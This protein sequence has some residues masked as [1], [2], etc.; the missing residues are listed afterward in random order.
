MA[1]KTK[2]SRNASLL[3]SRRRK[4]LIFSQLQRHEPTW[5]LLELLSS[6]V[7]PLLSNISFSVPYLTVKRSLKMYFSPFLITLGYIKPCIK[8]SL[9]VLVHR[10]V[11]GLPQIS[12]IVVRALDCQKTIIKPPK[13]SKRFLKHFF[14]VLNCHSS[15]CWFFF[16]FFLVFR[17]FQV[18]FQSVISAT[19]CNAAFFTDSPECRATEPWVFSPHRSWSV[20]WWCHGLQRQTQNFVAFVGMKHSELIRR[21]WHKYT[22]VQGAVQGGGFAPIALPT[23]VLRSL[24]WD[25]FEALASSERPKGPSVRTRP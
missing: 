1:R 4:I 12:D 25:G 14:W 8:A 7:F 3:L 17:N 9:Y 18:L 6:E 19:L 2:P 5:T 13:F 15:A 11:L 10:Q 20:C 21:S 16:F 24:I 23:H 22:A